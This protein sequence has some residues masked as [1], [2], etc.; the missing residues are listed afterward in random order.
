MDIFSYLLGKKNSSGGGSLSDYFTNEISF[1]G[2]GSMIKKI[3]DSVTLSSEV[4]EMNGFFYG[5][6]NITTI[7]L[8]NT[9]N[10]TNMSWTFGECLNLKTIPEIDT[11]NVT[12]FEGMFYD[13]ES[14]EIVPQF[15]GSSVTGDSS[16]LLQHMFE[17]C[18]SLSNESL[19]NILKFLLTCVN[20][21]GSK[22]LRFIGLNSTQ[23]NYCTTLNE[24]QT[25]VSNGWIT[26]Y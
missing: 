23:A 12:T 19:R 11:S 14:L 1:S 9:G 22:R 15:D 10:V 17:G 7:P 2:A 20:Y 18:S 25:L 21:T 13:C 24:W 5:W 16:E 26:G 3:P 8:L 4:T 6:E